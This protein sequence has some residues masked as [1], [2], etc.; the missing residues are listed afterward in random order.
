MKASEF[1]SRHPTAV[2]QIIVG[3][4]FAMYFLQRDDIVWRFVK[5]SKAPVHFERS[6][7]A[8]AT[9]LVG[10][11]AFL[12]TRHAHA[13]QSLRPNPKNVEEDRRRGYGEI[14]YAIGLGSLAPLAGFVI[15]VG[16]EALR[17]LRLMAPQPAEPF[18]IGAVSQPGRKD[19]APGFAKWGMFATLIVFTITLSDR[20]AEVL[21]SIVFTAAIALNLFPTVIYQNKQRSS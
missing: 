21:A 18:P 14:L 3:A 5:T 10:T 1:E 19:F 9:L 17:I 11:A 8:V 13:S 2:H 6:L 15:L 16:G 20:I 12:C 4:A 7:F